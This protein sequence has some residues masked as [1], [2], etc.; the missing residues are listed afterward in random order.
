MMRKEYK[1]NDEQH[2][3]GEKESTADCRACH[4]PE[5]RVIRSDTWGSGDRSIGW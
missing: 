1:P 2:D 4:Q 5:R 3:E